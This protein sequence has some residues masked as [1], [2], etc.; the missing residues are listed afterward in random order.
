MRNALFLPIHNHKYEREAS[1]NSVQNFN[2]NINKK[3]K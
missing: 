1:R 2:K 3:L